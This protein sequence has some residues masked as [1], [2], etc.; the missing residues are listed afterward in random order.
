MKTRYFQFL[1]IILLSGI[2]SSN[3]SGQHS[4]QN[5]NKNSSDQTVSKTSNY[6]DLVGGYALENNGKV[7]ISI[8][9]DQGNAE[10]N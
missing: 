7:Q 8:L 9:K 5:A 3:S 10:F 4:Y 2:F 1:L 6:D